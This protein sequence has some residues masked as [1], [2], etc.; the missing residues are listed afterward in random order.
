MLALKP[1]LIG[2][3]KVV[4]TTQLSRFYFVHSHF[5]YPP[6]NMILPKLRILFED[7]HLIAI[8]KRAGD[9]S[10]GDQTGDTPIGDQLK[11][12][13]KE[14][15]NK[16]GDVFLGVIHRLDRPVSGVNV[17]ARTSK[18]LKRMNKSFQDRTVQKVY[19]AIVV[20]RPPLEEDTLIHYLQKDREK[21]FVHAYAKPRP[22]AKMAELEYK[23]LAS[24]GNHHLLEIR[25][26]TAGS[27]KFGCSW[28]KLVVRLKGIKK[29]GN[30]EFNADGSIHL[31]CRSMSFP[32]PVLKT[33][34]TITAALPK[35]TKFGS[36][37]SIFK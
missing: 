12:Y 31:H 36:C 13:I 25:P 2:T 26:H 37:L 15:Y 19:W 32:H 35:E 11:Q 33:P 23:L 30:T 8:N 20:A 9:L 24:L 34:L 7:N 21:N 29:Y 16:P 10:K 22:G 18:A 4:S 14:K 6:T 17:F 1:T 27:T 28:P 3:L 5:F